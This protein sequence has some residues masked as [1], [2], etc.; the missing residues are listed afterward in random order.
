[1]ADGLSDARRHSSKP[2]AVDSSTSNKHV[3]AIIF[4]SRNCAPGSAILINTVF[5]ASV[6]PVY[7]FTGTLKRSGTAVYQTAAGLR[8]SHGESAKSTFFYRP[9]T[10]VLTQ[11][12]I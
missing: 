8:L 6:Q 4:R 9:D 11:W 2:C 7:R 1:T 10:V 5:M 3:S 12:P